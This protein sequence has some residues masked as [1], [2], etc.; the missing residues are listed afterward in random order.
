MLERP[1]VPGAL[2][3]D[4]PAQRQSRVVTL[5]L[6]GILPIHRRCVEGVV[7]QEEEGRPM[8]LVRARLRHHVHDTASAAAELRL[9]AGVDDLEFLN[10]VLREILKNAASNIITI[11]ESID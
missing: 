2:S 8:H 7:A 9:V 10:R 5:E 11:L 1:E 3:D 6:R 4:R